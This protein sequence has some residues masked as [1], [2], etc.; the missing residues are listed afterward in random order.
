MLFNLKQRFL[1]SVSEARSN[2][3]SSHSISVIP[4][5]SFS[6]VS[7]IS[8]N[9]GWNTVFCTLSIFSIRQSQYGQASIQLQRW[10]SVSLKFFVAVKFNKKISALNS[11]Q[12]TEWLNSLF[13]ICCMGRYYVIELLTSLKLI[14][15][16]KNK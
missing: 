3:L 2:D 5:Q 6:R 4:S 1:S 9:P 12:T 7:Q 15:F 10:S 8:P 14:F 13:L 16:K 11:T